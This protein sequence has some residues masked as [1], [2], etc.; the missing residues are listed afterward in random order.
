MRR[1]EAATR[2][3]LPDAHPFELQGV[4][5]D[6]GMQTTR[7]K[8]VVPMEDDNVSRR[9]GRQAVAVLISSTSTEMHGMLA[10]KAGVHQD[11]TPRQRPCARDECVEVACG[12]R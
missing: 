11:P 9:E 4:G 1:L 6:H 8:P 12:L 5:V 10:E 2:I 3:F 7:G